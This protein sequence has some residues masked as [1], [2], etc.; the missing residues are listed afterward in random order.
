MVGSEVEHAVL[1]TNYFTSLGKKAYLVLG[2]G[3]PEGQTAYVLTAEESG[4][5]WLWNVVTGEHFNTSETFCPLVGVTAVVDEC[6]VWGNV[7][8]SDAPNRMKWDLTNGS[9]WAPLFG[10]HLSLPNLSSV[11]PTQLS[12]SQPDQRAA[13][14]LKDKIEKKIK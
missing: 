2:Q 1:M 5:H 4:Q 3:I 11:Q 9:D 10:S 6:N 8:S 14:T 13:T 12:T 7:Q